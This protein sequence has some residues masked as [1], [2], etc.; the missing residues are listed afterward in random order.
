MKYSKYPAIL[1]LHLSLILTATPLYSEKP[2]DSDTTV[3]P[4]VIRERYKIT[5]PR[6]IVRGSVL[7]IRIGVPQNELAS[8]EVR[9]EVNG[10]A[11]IQEKLKLGYVGTLYNSDDRV[12]ATGSSFPV[13]KKEA[14]ERKETDEYAE[15]ADEYILLGL[16][17]TITPGVYRLRIEKDSLPES[18]G[19]ALLFQE[20]IRIL[21]GTFKSEI[22][23]L[24]REMSKLRSEPDPRK[25]AEAVEIQGI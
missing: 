11:I 21:P 8:E 19:R 20:D 14:A 9:E 18:Q 1:L 17:S 16:G 12:V 2:P 10:D 4:T 15:Y 5:F 3:I 24:N 25:V 22:I 23:P 6:E 7:A 13:A